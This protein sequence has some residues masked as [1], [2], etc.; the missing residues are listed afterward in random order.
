M[1]LKTYTTFILALLFTSFSLTAQV[2]YSEDFSGGAIPDG[3][4]NVDLTSNAGEEVFFQFSTNPDDVNALGN[5]ETET[6]LATTAAGGY[7]YADSDRG[8]SGA[9]TNLHTTQLTTTPI[10]CSDKDAV[11]IQFETL[12]GVFEQNAETAALLRISTDAGVNWT[13]FTVFPNLTTSVRW[14]ENPQS[15]SIDI[16]SV[17]ANEAAVMIQ[18]QWIGGWEYFWAID[19]IILTTEDP[20]PAN[21]MRINPFAAVA[22]NAITPVSQIEPIGFIADIENVGSQ[23]QT[24]VKMNMTIVN[25]SNSEVFSDVLE[26]GDITSDSL[27][28]NKFFANEFTPPAMEQSYTAT[29]ALDYESPDVDP[30]ADNNTYSFNFEVSDTTFAKELGRTRG[31]AP[32]GGNDYTYGNIFYVAN[33]TDADGNQLYARY[34]SFA[35]SNAEELAGKTVNVFLYAW[36]G[37]LDSD[38]R[39]IT[40]DLYSFEGI[41][42][43]TFT[44]NESNDIITLLANDGDAIPLQANTYYIPAIQY[45]DTDDTAFFLEASEE[46]DYAA[47]NFYT[48]SLDTH[49]THY[50]TAL[51]FG[52]EGTLDIIGFGRDIVPVIRL[53]IGT[54]PLVAT[55]EIQ[56]PADAISVFP[57]PAKESA[58]VAINLAEATNGTLQVLDIQGKIVQ[59]H[60][61]NNIQREQIQLNTGNLP[62]GQYTLSVKTALGVSNQKL[63][64]QH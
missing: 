42:E 63:V 17:A 48:D 37:T 13:D 60:Q 52:N 28:E 14:S 9:P 30:N 25:Q 39:S 15:V 61:L 50:S 41:N 1:Q 62:S 23:T 43:Y 53:S 56:L 18:W 8:L 64:V 16:T 20:R 7:L 36:D 58:T 22:P 10:D 45:F 54:N 21:D 31:L 38:R 49:P 35:V 11:Y 59:T 12:I 46:F 33:A 55:K 4:T 26:Y 57:N 2:F 5:A 44:G 6:F 24:A 40:Q 29:Y 47:T 19:D 51:D 32:S 34:I 3:W 27:A